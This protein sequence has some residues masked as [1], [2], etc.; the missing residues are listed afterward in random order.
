[1]SFDFSKIKDDARGGS[2]K[3]NP[4]VDEDPVVHLTVRLSNKMMRN[5]ERLI[6]SRFDLKM[7][8]WRILALLG[9][10]SS[11][12]MQAVCDEKMILPNEVYVN[13]VKLQNRGYIDFEEADVHSP[14]HITAE[15][16]RVYEKVLPFMQQRQARL[17]AHLSDDGKAM[18]TEIAT[19]LEQIFDDEFINIRSEKLTFDELADVISGDDAF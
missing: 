15:G 2:M 14:A 3:I 9:V 12:T 4:T 13:A 5:S 16:R 6:E 7:T 11:L 17:M 19:G 18:L 10:N 1:M 8:E